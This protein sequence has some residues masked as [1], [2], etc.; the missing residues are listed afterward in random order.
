M[1]KRAHEPRVIQS[2]R[3]N[4]ANAY[5]MRKTRLSFETVL[6]GPSVSRPLSRV[7]SGVMRNAT[8]CEM[9]PVMLM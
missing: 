9:L 4:C 1:P 6:P 3:L 5:L 2:S 8:M 7:M